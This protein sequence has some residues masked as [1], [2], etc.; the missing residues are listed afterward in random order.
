MAAS[1]PTITQL[2]SDCEKEGLTVPNGE[3]I[4]IGLAKIFGVQQEEVGLLKLE[5]ESLVFVHPPKLN[6]VGRIPLNSPAVA[7][8]TVHSKH[9][10][11]INNFTRTRHATFFEMVDVSSKP[12]PTKSSKEHLVIQK[13]MS[14]PVLAQDRVIG[15]IQICRKGATAE[16]AGADFTPTELQNLISLAAVLEK[17]FAKAAV[18]V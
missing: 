17:C 9:P 11:I 1:A 2:L 6:K 13:L 14:V 4:A 12:G 18:G 15:V 10:E 16:A 5:K 8:H 3:K 7:A